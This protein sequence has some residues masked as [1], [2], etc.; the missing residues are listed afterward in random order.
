MISPQRNWQKNAGQKNKK[1]ALST[2]YFFALHF[3]AL[4]VDCQTNRIRTVHQTYEIHE[5]KVRNAEDAEGAENSHFL[6]FSALQSVSSFH[7]AKVFRAVYGRRT[8][9]RTN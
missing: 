4:F 9:N 1:K 6:V 5:K 7:A 2:N 8:T 3:F